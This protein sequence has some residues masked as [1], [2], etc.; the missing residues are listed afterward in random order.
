MRSIAWHSAKQ[1]RVPRKGC[2]A[3]IGDLQS[4]PVASH[5]STRNWNWEFLGTRNWCENSIN[6]PSNAF[7]CTTACLTQLVEYRFCKPAVIGS[8]P[9]VGSF[10]GFLR[11]TRFGYWKSRL[12][13]LYLASHHGCQAI[14]K[15]QDSK[16]RSLG[17]Q[18]LLV[19]ASH[20]R[21]VC[22]ARTGRPWPLALPWHQFPIRACFA[23][24]ALHS[25]CKAHVPRK[26]FPDS[27]SYFLPSRVSL[28]CAKQRLAP[29]RDKRYALG[30]GN[31]FARKGCAEQ[32]FASVRRVPWHR[33]SQARNSGCGRCYFRT[34]AKIAISRFRKCW[35]LACL[36]SNP[37][38]LR[39]KQFRKSQAQP[40]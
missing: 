6:R 27:N 31:C 7:L 9:V 4:N 40:L 2:S 18:P 34:R 3:R 37:C 38:L 12:L 15:F 17:L 28:G 23:R 13:C 14:S 22:F 8:I 30:I 26:P 39:T 1:F 32:S 25:A 36:Q 20:A 5:A 10:K 35:I 24:V 11:A 29:A 33:N 21:H 19:L 16:S